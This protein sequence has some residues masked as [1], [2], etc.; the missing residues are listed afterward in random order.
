M[1]NRRH[2]KLSKLPPDVLEAVHKRYVEG[3]TYEAI[4]RWLNEMGHPISR[5]AV[6]RDGKDFLARLDKLN[7]VKKQAVAIVEEAGGKGALAME[8]AAALLAL[9][10][11]IEYLMEIPDWEGEKA[12]AVMQAIARLQSSSVNREKLKMDFRDK[13]AEAAEAVGKMA[14]AEGLSDELAEQIK[15][16]ILGVAA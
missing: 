6:G 9:Q 12:T 14:K 10:G 8:E 16:K 3:H 11:A 4:T 2:S 15:K 1:G 5:A 13:A 7:V